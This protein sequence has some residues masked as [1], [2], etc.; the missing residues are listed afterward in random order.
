MSW[1][2]AAR[3]FGPA[4]AKLGSEIAE[5]RGKHVATLGRDAPQ[6]CFDDDGGRE[7]AQQ[8]IDGQSNAGGDDEGDEAD[9]SDQR[10]DAAELVGLAAGATHRRTAAVVR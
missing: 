3:T 7:Q 9:P 2:R 10:I 1:Q 6:S 8:Q 5:Q 4:L